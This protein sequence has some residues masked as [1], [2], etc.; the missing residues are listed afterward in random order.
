MAIPETAVQENVEL[1]SG[2]LAVLCEFSGIRDY[3][4]GSTEGPGALDRLR[5]RSFKA[6]AYGRLVARRIQHDL[7]P[8]L[9]T[10][11]LSTGRFLLAGS[12]RGTAEPILAGFQKNLDEWALR[13][14][15]G[16]LHPHLVT[17]RCEDQR[18]PVEALEN[19]LASRGLRPL[20]GTLLQGAYWNAGAF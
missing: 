6:A 8:E 10:V 17:A 12:A 1:R 2:D 15:R 7:V 5:A 11:Y 14:L 18:L 9:R 3:V 19:K 4:L 16:E 13:Q 20:E